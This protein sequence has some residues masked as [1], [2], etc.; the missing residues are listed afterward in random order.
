MT[1][2]LVAVV[3]F[4]ARGGD[5]SRGGS[6]ARQIARRL[7]DRFADHPEV[8]LQPVF[9][10]A[11][12][13]GEGGRSS[14]VF[15]STPDPALAAQYGR[16]LGAEH[17]LVGVWR[18]DAGSR[19]L[20]ATLVDVATARAGAT[21]THPVADGELPG[22]EAALARWLAEALGVDPPGGLATAPAANEAAYAA[23][24]EGAEDEV[25]RTL[26][27]ESDPAGAAAALDRALARYLAA[28][29][30]DP[31]STAAEERL[32][33]LAAESL[34]GHDEARHIAALAQLTAIRPRSWRAHYL[35]GELRQTSGDAPGAIVALEHSDAL[36]ALSDRDALRLAELYLDANAPESAAAR[37][38]RIPT[39]SGEYPLAQGAFGLIAWQKG[40]HQAA[41][42]AFKRA[43]AAGGPPAL[44]LDLARASILAG[45]REAATAELEHLLRES[46]PGPERAQ[47]L[48]LRFGLRHPDLEQ[49][50][51]VAG[52]AV[53]EGDGAALADAQLGL[54]QVRDAEPDLW[55][56]HFGLGLVARRRGDAP[57]AEAAFRRV[58]ELWPDQADALHELGVALLSGD[59]ATD[60]VRVLEAA[61]LARP[62]D[63]GYLADAGL[64]QLRSGNLALARERLERARELDADDPMTNAY[65][66][67]LAR[68]EAA[69]RRPS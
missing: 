51:E 44:R 47:A 12:P 58:L 9:L 37:L 6:W 18:E 21:L 52:R 68:L 38:R 11:L 16:S 50:L 14:L 26:L 65:L 3:P 27:R 35:L 19:A 49:L 54:E 64:A 45:D 63:P 60:A 56:A 4:G 36:H 8:A 46:A 20:Q 41:T 33:V 66:A 61:S 40:D 24:L 34:E 55:E 43:L 2:T 67:E 25:S 30:A 48:R 28:A 57:R 29:R 13:E 10:V 59:R 5:P 22:V 62:Q 1:R 17:A 42:A 31:E 53:V 32:L 39:T 69:T 7:V 15:G 23:L